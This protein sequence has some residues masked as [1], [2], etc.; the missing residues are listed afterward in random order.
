MKIT[1]STK[2]TISF[3]VEAFWSE[4]G[5]MGSDHLDLEFKLLK[6]LFIN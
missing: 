1:K 4:E 5:G 3:Q 6:R 2:Y